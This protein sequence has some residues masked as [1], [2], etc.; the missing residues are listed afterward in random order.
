MEISTRSLIGFI[1][2]GKI[3]ESQPRYSTLLSPH[4]NEDDES[5]AGAEAEAEADDVLQYDNDL[6]DDVEERMA[7][8]RSREVNGCR[9][10]D[11][12]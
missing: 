12:I 3:L 6:D 1:N 8:V 11:S 7:L 9:N 4:A 10:F 5:E 2:L